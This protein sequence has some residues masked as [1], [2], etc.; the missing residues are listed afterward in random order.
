MEKDMKHNIQNKVIMIDAKK[1]KDRTVQ[2]LILLSNE[3]ITCI[4]Q[5]KKV[6]IDT[7]E[8]WNDNIRHMVSQYDSNT[9]LSNAAVCER[10]ISK[11]NE[12]EH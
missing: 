1:R 3:M 6:P 2:G 7:I 10:L 4:K 11:A 8:Q 12:D 5:N 9:I